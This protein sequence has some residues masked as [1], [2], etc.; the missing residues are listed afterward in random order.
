MGITLANNAHTTLSADASS[1]DT[2]IYVEDIDSFPALDVGDYFYLTLE[3][4]SGAQEIVKVTQINASSF[5]VVRG[6]ESTIPISFSIGS[7][8]KLNMTVQNITDLIVTGSNVNDEAYGTSWDGDTSDAPSR[9]TV[10]DKI[11]TLLPSASYTAADVLSKLLTVDG[12]GSGLDADLLDGNSSA[13]F[14]PATTYTAAD[15]LSKLLTVDGTGSLL[16]ADLL[17]GYEATAFAQLSGATFSGDVTVGGGDLVVG[18]T[19]YAGIANLTLKYDNA[20]GYSGQLIW[21][22]DGTTKWY[23]QSGSTGSWSLRN[24][25]LGTDAISFASAS[26]NA[27]FTGTV[28]VPDDAYAAGWD[29]N[30][31]TPTKNAVYDKIACYS[32]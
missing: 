30:L 20:V 26:N 11:E 4:T 2:V 14:L 28:T 31:T 10:Y 25:G 27:T 18:S 21:E 29:G 19:K 17:D 32:C 3:R 24:N 8:A 9:N 23:A 15:V 13:Y 5:N 22:R 1:T 12:T 16:D 6:Q 7:M